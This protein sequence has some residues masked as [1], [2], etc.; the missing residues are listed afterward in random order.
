MI[1][2]HAHR[3]IFVKTLKTAGT[4][5]EIALSQ[6]C[7]PQDIIT[8]IR[9]EDEQTRRDLGLRG[10]QN[11][12]LPLA[13]YQPADWHRL[14]F[15]RRRAWYLNHMPA[16]DI[17][18]RLGA[19]IW[20]SYTKFTIER[21]PWDCAVSR[22]FWD[23][24]DLPDRPTFAD[25]LASAPHLSNFPIYAIDGVVA[26]DHV[27]RYENLDAGLDWLQDALHLPERPILP[28]AKSAARPDRRPYSE[29]F[30][31]ATRDFVARAC[32]REIEL[33][34]YQFEAAIPS[35]KL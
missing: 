24:R 17:R 35:E 12:L 22:Y 31:P 6:F 3:F 5:M 1:V 29:L 32:A 7:G 33:F 26:V 8:R 21:N 19:K 18:P 23:T 13:R 30:T 14:F 2:S 25:Y 4:S 15:E 9:P 28:R 20:D 11:D 34:G 27:I 16:R 10:R